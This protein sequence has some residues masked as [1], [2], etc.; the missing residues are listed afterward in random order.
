MFLFMWMF[1]FGV[2]LLFS[3]RWRWDWDCGDL[4]GMCLELLYMALVSG[5]SAAGSWLLVTVAEALA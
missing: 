4:Q 5:V 2:L 1:L 3:D